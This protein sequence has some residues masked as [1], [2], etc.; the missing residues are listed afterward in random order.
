M[1]AAAAE[2]RVGAP[3][4]HESVAARILRILGKAPVHLILVLV[5]LLWLVP[6]LG[7]LLTS[8]LAPEDRT[9]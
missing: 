8:L 4:S 5:G 2:A 9:A 1:T 6:T 7:L 3:R